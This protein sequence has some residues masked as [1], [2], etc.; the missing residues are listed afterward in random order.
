LGRDIVPLDVN[1][2]IAKLHEHPKE[3]MEMRSQSGLASI[4]GQRWVAH[5]GWF[6]FIEFQFT[7]EEVFHIKRGID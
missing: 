6:S 7:R 5:E 2:T 4:C 1:Q 3:T